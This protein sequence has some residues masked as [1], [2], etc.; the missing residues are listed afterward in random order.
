[1]NFQVN[2]K[3]GIELYITSWVF[4]HI[5]PKRFIMKN[6]PLFYTRVDSNSYLMYYR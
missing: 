3:S 2:I 4:L 6:Q 5:P 1:M